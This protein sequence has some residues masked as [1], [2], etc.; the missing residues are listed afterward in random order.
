MDKINREIK[1]Y[2][3][4]YYDWCFVG[5]DLYLSG[6]LSE[7]YHPIIEIKFTDVFMVSL[8]TSFHTE[9][10]LLHSDFIREEIDRELNTKYEIEIGYKKYVIND[11]FF[12]IAK[13]VSLIQSNDT[14]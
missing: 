8:R 12:V 10:D 13:D 4:L 3:W 1:R 6:S 7:T 14:I 11:I 5:P 9:P 2:D